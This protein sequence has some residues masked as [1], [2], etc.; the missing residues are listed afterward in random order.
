MKIKK[1]SPEKIALVKAAVKRLGIKCAANRERLRR[2]QIEE[3]KWHDETYY[4]FLRIID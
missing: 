3:L 4:E 1:L 2:E